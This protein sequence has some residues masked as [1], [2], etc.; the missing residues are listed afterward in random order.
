MIWPQAATFIWKTHY[1]HLLCTCLFN[2]NHTEIPPS[3]YP[4]PPWQDAPPPSGMYMESVPFARY[5]N[6]T[7]E[8]FFHH[9]S[10]GLLTLSMHFIHRETSWK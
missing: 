2:M 8:D 1:C 4:V 6:L 5:V 7:M 9:I 3:Q 10:A